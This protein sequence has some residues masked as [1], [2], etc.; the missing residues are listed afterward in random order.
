M[1]FHLEMHR[2]YLS[3]LGLHVWDFAIY[4]GLAVSGLAAAC[5]VVARSPAVLRLA[6]AFGLTMLVLLVS[7]SAQGE[8]GRVWIFFIPIVLLLA[9]ASIRQLTPWQRSLMLGAQI[10]WL[11]VLT[12]SHKPVDTWLAPAPVYAEVARPPL[13]GSLIPANAIFGNE[14]RLTGFQS[15]YHPDRRVLSVALHWQTLRQMAVPYYFSAV[16][17]AP[18]G[19]ALPGMHGQP[20]GKQ[21]PATCWRPGSS[22]LEVVDQIELPLGD[23]VT[24]GNWWLSLSVFTIAGDRS[25]PSLPVHLADGSQD[26]QFGLGPLPIETR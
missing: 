18:D 21:Y 3:S 6:L 22:A 12:A 14:L 9:A 17:V 8:V 19:R 16:P 23:A 26:Q 4:S 24:P 20:F 25:Q 13:N 10:L 1:R 2:S 15:E 5:V 11:V 7:G